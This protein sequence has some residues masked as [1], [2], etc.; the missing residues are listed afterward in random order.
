MRKTGR[1]GKPVNLSISDDLQV[2]GYKIARADRL[3]GLTALVERLII[4]EAKR[5][6]V[7]K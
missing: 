4:Q 3:S 1:K 7:L 5:R 6:G 2:I